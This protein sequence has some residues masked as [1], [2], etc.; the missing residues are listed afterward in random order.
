MT[1]AKLE[2][3]LARLYSDEVWA[4]AVLADPARLDPVARAVLA[5]IDRT[6]LELAQ[7]S[8][9]AKRAARAKS[10]ACTRSCCAVRSS[11]SR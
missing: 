8:F 10:P 1:G 11:C 5:T 3:F 2:A 6:G 4:S 7:R 9:A